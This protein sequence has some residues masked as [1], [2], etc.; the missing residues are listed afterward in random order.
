M[1]PED[2][3]KHPKPRVYKCQLES[4][5]LEEAVALYTGTGP[6]LQAAVD[7]YKRNVFLAVSLTPF[8]LNR[9]QPGLFAMHSKPY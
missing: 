6:S 3:L 5:V 4:W 2:P 9:W 8:S 7:L 1:L